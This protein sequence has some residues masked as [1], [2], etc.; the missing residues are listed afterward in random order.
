MSTLLEL[1][2]VRSGYGSVPVLRDVSLTVDRGEIVALLGANGAGKSTT[3][4]TV[5]GE[6]K[7]LGG[8]IRVDGSALRGPLNRRVRRGM[9]LITETRA[10]FPSLTVADNLRLGRGKVDDAVALFPELGPLMSRRA[11]LLSGGEQQML[12]VSRALAARPELLLVDELSLGLAPLA[13][14]RLLAA[15]V[16]ASAFGTG[17]LLVEQHARKALE[18]A[19]HGYVLCRGAVNLA[20][21]GRELLGRDD[22]VRRAYLHG[23]AGAAEDPTTKA[24]G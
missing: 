1:R 3:M 6:L 5:G 20:G 23:S 17:V 11:G 10:L 16:E 18:I 9:A 15:I 14:D 7:L 12:S 8:E 21:T 13:V 4:L 22:E 2:D 19:T 24:A